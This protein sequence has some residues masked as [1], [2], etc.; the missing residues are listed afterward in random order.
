MY[1]YILFD[2]D[3]TLTDSK[4][5][6]CKSVQYALKKQGIDEPSLDK[7]EIFIGPSLSYS[8]KEFYHMDEESTAKAIA[9]YRERFSATGLYENALYDGVTE[10]LEE[11][12]NNDMHLAVASSKP[13]VF[14][15]RILKHFKI[16]RYFDVVVGSELDGTRSD[17]TEVVNEALRQLYN[18][19][20]NDDVTAYLKDN[21][22]IRLSTVMVGDRK[23]DIKGAKD[24]GIDSIGADYGF[25]PKGELKA[26]GAGYIAT[27]VNA[28]K[29][30]ILGLDK[31][32]KSQDLESKS[33]F[34][35]SLNVILPLVWYYF[36][37]MLVSFIG[38]VVTNSINK[39]GDKEK[40]QYITAHSTMISGIIMLV[41]LLVTSA[42]LILLFKKTDEIKVSFNK[43]HGLYFVSG[44]MLAIALNVILTKIAV[45]SKLEALKYQESD[46]LKNL[47]LFMG[48]VIFVIL[49]PFL[50]ELLF[51]WLIYGRMK[52]MLNVSVAV[53]F[54]AVFFGFYHGNLLQGIYAFI[55]GMIMAV[56]YEKSGSIVAPMLYHIGANG[57]VYILRFVPEAITNVMSGIFASVVFLIA[58]IILL[59]T[60]YKGREN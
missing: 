34:F 16:N 17:K 55:M 26:E 37:M 8:F 7:L 60:G 54:S 28:L 31:K 38:L 57:F 52:K 49:S 10:M 5:G 45:A 48:F 20:E 40:I 24:L 23:Y 47:P 27:N 21:K 42:V 33:S 18:L 12:K 36:M 46:M 39:S 14:V 44:G 41:S 51:R 6:I 19:S 4:E 58:G 29:Q 30:H 32:K 9:D 1:K 3:G 15:K 50:E 22:D 25:A 2:L 13:E 53:I 11:L 59:I 43:I 56:I 35:K